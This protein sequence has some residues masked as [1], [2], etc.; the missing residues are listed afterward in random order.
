MLRRRCKADRHTFL[1]IMRTVSVVLAFSVWVSQLPL[2]RSFSTTHRHDVRP[3]HVCR[4]RSPLFGGYVPD[5][6]SPEEYAKI[7]REEAVRT[8][9][10]NFGKFGP[11]FLKSNRPQGDWF[12]MPS[13]WTAGFD[14]NRRYMSSDDNDE[15]T[16]L[17]KRIKHFLQQWWP[18]MLL[19]YLAIDI[20]IAMEA[21]LRAAEMKP[22]QLI[23][24]FIKVFI[25]AKRQNMWLVWW[26]AQSTKCA[27]TLVLM[28]PMQK[29]II[30]Y[31]ESKFQWT[32]RRTVIIS[33][34]VMIG[35]SLG[36]SLFL[37]ALKH[38]HLLGG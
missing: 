15:E 14:L 6:L 36:W 31:A 32:R 22:R 1:F 25:W 18:A 34:S 30:D 19:S 7:K 4:R 2:C 5:G 28:F 23:G 16:S 20:G 27:L 11:R 37:V 8:K 9:S 13:L 33:S 35:A 10:M 21:S 26:K 38:F 3:S 12:L 24:T 29:Y 17:F